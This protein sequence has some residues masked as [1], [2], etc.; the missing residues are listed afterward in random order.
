MAG[1]A[2]QGGG[3]AKTLGAVVVLIA[4]IIGG[5]YFYKSGAFSRG[6]E[7]APEISR[8]Q[9][10]GEQ[11]LSTGQESAITK[12]KQEILTRIAAGTPLTQGEKEALGKLMLMEAHLYGFTDAETEAIFKALKTQ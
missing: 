2:P 5:W 4:V 6:V 7:N 9:L 1:N 3:S 8:E 11:K 12:H 10:V